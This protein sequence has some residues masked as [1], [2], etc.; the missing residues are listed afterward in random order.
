MRARSKSVMVTLRRQAPA[1]SRSSS[2]IWISHWYAFLVLFV[3]HPKGDI[4]SCMDI[5]DASDVEEGHLETVGFVSVVD[6][7]D[8]WESLP[9]FLTK[10]VG[11]NESNN[12]TLKLAN[13][14]LDPG[15]GEVLEEGLCRGIATK[16][17]SLRFSHLV[18]D[19]SSCPN[20][21]SW[22]S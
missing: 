17:L 18:L 22:Q 21:E 9:H 2:S 13:A 20:L 12:T 15:V 8:I 11:P 4:E 6:R 7:D 10:G 16:G 5:R 14:V 19:I 1:S 3:D